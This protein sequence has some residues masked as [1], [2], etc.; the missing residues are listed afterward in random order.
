[1]TPTT[2]VLLITTILVV[3]CGGTVPRGTPPETDV[4]YCVRFSYLDKTD[5]LH[6]AQACVE[7]EST[8]HHVIDLLEK[9]GRLGNVQEIGALRGDVAVNRWTITRTFFAGMALGDSRVVSWTQAVAYNLA[10][11]EVL[12]ADFIELL[13]APWIERAQEV[14]A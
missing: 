1:V 3:G 13:A 4:P 10:A 14:A 6:V 8:C 7:V 9:F 5:R 2:K 11:S 12:N